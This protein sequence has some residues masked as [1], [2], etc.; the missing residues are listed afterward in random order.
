M[1]I[2]SLKRS[3]LTRIKKYNSASSGNIL[4]D[5]IIIAGGGGA[6]R[7]GALGWQYSPG[8]G[9]G[10]F[11]SGS[12]QLSGTLT[13]TIGAGGSSGDLAQSGFDGTASS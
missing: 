6:A 10:G 12:L 9:A 11:K 4:A 13:V 3:S 7:G 8:G 2:T 1:A 5:Y